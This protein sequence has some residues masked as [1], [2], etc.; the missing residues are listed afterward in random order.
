MSN[1]FEGDFRG[2]AVKAEFGPD[3]NGKLKLRIV[4]EITEGPRTGTQV[5]YEGSFGKEYIGYTK[6]D[7]IALGWQGK[8]SGTI[9]SDVLADPK[10]VPFQTRI[11]EKRYE[12]TGKVSQWTSVRSIGF[13]APPL[14]P[15]EAH[16]I[17]DVDSWFN[18]AS[19]SPQQSQHPN[20]P[21]N[22]TGR[23]PF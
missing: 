12:D 18:E 3:K 4:L 2:K 5:P 13:E 17:K 23:T 9:V 6:R 7:L 16:H 10:V 14:K 21:G 19:D 11:A 8:T 1:L 15:A 20:A 22:G